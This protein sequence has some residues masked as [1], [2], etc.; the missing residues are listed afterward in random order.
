MVEGGSELQVVQLGAAPAL[1]HTGT[2][3][4]GS[5]GENDGAR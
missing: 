3:G 1:G 4:C 5:E 2:V